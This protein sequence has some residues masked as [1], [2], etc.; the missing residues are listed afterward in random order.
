MLKG[1]QKM[2]AGRGRGEDREKAFLLDFYQWL[3]FANSY[4]RSTGS[5][6]LQLVFW[7]FFIQEMCG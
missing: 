6:Q 7:P 1:K 5:V 3:L 4:L 2:K